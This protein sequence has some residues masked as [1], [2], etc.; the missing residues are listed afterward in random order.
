[1]LSAQYYASSMRAM[2]FRLCHEQFP[3]WPTNSSEDT[4]R[5]ASAAVLWTYAKLIPCRTVL[6]EQHISRVVMLYT[7]QLHVYMIH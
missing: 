2:C 5:A 3:G 4:L 1:M 6:S 7:W